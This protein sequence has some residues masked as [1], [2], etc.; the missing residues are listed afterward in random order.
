MFKFILYITGA[1]LPFSSIAGLLDLM[2]GI[3]PADQMSAYDLET[4][5]YHTPQTLGEVFSGGLYDIAHWALGMIGL[6]LWG[7]VSVMTGFGALGIHIRLGMRRRDGERRRP[8][9]LGGFLWGIVI[10]VGTAKYVIELKE[11]NVRIMKAIYLMVDNWIRQ[12]QIKL[13]TAILEVDP[14]RE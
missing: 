3:D 12:Y 10:L 14:D 5:G 8:G 1:R 7:F 9:R 13:E 4:W 6:A 2:F 11:V